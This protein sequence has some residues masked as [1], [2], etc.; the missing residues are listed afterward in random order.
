MKAKEALDKACLKETKEELDSKTLTLE[1]A[2]EELDITKE[3]LHH[4]IEQLHRQEEYLYAM[5][6]DLE[7]NKEELITIHKNPC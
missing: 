7:I 6:E 2:E 4:E 3:E 5:K 1:R